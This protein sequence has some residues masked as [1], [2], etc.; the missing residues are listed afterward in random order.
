MLKI[1]G[2]GCELTILSSEHLIIVAEGRLVLFVIL[3][4]R[5][6]T[7][8]VETWYTVHLMALTS[9]KLLHHFSRV[10]LVWW[11]HLLHVLS[12]TKNVEIR[13]CVVHVSWSS[14]ISS[15]LVKTIHLSGL[16]IRS[17]SFLL[18]FVHW[19]CV[20]SGMFSLSEGYVRFAFVV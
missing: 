2:M 7:V 17:V 16:S 6:S 11:G 19:F 13:S 10:G 1:V 15:F 9:T 20:A 5:N 14:R 4:P 3:D 8:L 18:N 12:W